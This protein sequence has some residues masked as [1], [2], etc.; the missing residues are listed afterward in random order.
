LEKSMKNEEYRANPASLSGRAAI[1][2]GGS[3]GIG[4]ATAELL[5]ERGAHVFICAR[6]ASEVASTVARLRERFGAA[7]IHG[8]AIDLENADSI[9][10][11]FDEAEQTL[12][13]KIRILVNNAAIGYAIPFLETSAAVLTKEWDRMQ[14]INIRAPLLLSHEL[15]RRIPRGEKTGAIVNLGSLGGIRGTDK[16]PG[17]AA[18]VATK[19]AIAG[20]TEALAV[21]GR[22]IGVRVN[23]VAPGAVDT[24]MLRK[25]APHLKTETRPADVAKVIAYLCDSAESGSVTG[26]IIEI[27][28]NL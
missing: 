10:A 28:S 17:L 9:S 8:K 15:M 3:R 26:T 25:A 13:D 12:G 6:T 11:L 22:S 23:A 20:L 21:E 4:E 14:A 5:L 16:F 18:Y 24:E 2:T 27:H 7:S 1:V 19:F